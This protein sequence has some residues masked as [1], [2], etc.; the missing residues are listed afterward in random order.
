M[1][2]HDSKSG[3]STPS[4][5][6]MGAEKILS[7]IF[8][9]AGVEVSSSELADIIVRDRSFFREVLTKG[10]LGLGDTYIVGKWDSNHIDEVVSRI[11][12]SG[13]HQRLAPVYDFVGRIRRQAMNLQNKKKAK[14]VI[15]MHYDLPA[16]FYESFLDPYFQYTCARFEGTDD[17]DE[18]Q[19]IKMENICQKLDLKAGDR[20][21]DVGGGW[22]GFAKFMAET[23]SANP[24]VVTLS[25]EQAE[26][27]RQRHTDK[28]E[29]LECDYRDIPGSF[30]GS[31]DAISIVGMMEHVGVKN[32]EEFMRALHQNLKVGGNLLL[33][34]LY[35]PYSRPASNPWSNKH[36]FPNGELASQEVIERELSRY[37]RPHSE[38]NHPVFEELTPNY[39]PTLRAWRNRLYIA[40]QS[41][42]IDMT[43]DEY[44]KW[45]YYFMSYAGAI[46]AK[47]VRIGQFLYKKGLQQTRS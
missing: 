2:N 47:H 11:L 13:V 7:V 16:S 25:K 23:H 35:T 12:E 39:P 26:H 46:D 27:I 22:G 41:G 15:E 5:I 24:T 30:E 21:L 40:R 3:N 20:V 38:S 10:S 33:H 42:E 32:Y 1:N 34:T 17:L 6:D 29:V 36:I 43:D 8:A 19:E 14:E 28:V 45:E 37:F 44:R 9:K 4:L 18:A 31:F